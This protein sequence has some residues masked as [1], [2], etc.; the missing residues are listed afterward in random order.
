VSWTC[1]LYLRYEFLKLLHT[2][3]QRVTEKGLLAGEFHC[4][5]Y[6]GKPSTVG[7]ILETRNSA[8]LMAAAYQ[9]SSF[10]AYVS[11]VLLILVARLT[12]GSLKHRHDA[13]MADRRCGKS[14]RNTK[15]IIYACIYLFGLSHRGNLVWFFGAARDFFLLQSVQTGSQTHPGTS[16]PTDK[17]AGEWRW[18]FTPSSAE[19]NVWSYTFTL[20]TP[21]WRTQGQLCLYLHEDD[22]RFSEIATGPEFNDVKSDR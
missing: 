5:A 3:H 7:K 4:F 21:S 2:R 13:V 8:L 18:S 20:H 19:K 9:P 17:A 14:V 1:K 15:G 11:F 22:K 10:R 12:N 6:D 16:S